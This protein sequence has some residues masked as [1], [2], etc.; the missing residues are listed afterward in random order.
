MNK[1]P[2]WRIFDEPKNVFKK[3]GSFAVIIPHKVV[4][5]LKLN[6]GDGLLFILDNRSG[7]VIIGTEKHFGRLQIGDRIA[8]LGFPLTVKE[9]E[10]LMKKL[11]V[12]KT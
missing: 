10:E 4:E 3:G 11:K 6:E 7:N 9:L 12:E 5:Y 1:V 8:T 2:E